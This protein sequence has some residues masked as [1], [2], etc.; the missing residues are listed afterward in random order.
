MVREATSRSQ[1]H[2][3]EKTVTRDCDKLSILAARH[4]ACSMSFAERK[5]TIEKGG[6]TTMKWLNRTVTVIFMSGSLAGTALGAD[7]V[8]LKQEFTPG[9]YCHMK[10]PAIRP[11][12]LATDQPELKQSDT[13]DIIDYYGSCDESPTGKDQVAEQKQEELRHW[14]H[15]LNRG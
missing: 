10:F 9:S 15:Y 3:E 5:H 13:G 4:V 6:E 12:T 14:R 1:F 2:R 7:G 11:K 8:L